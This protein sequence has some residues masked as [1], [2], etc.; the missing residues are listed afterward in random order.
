[1]GLLIACLSYGRLEAVRHKETVLAH[2]E[3]L[4][5][6]CKRASTLRRPLISNILGGWTKMYA[7]SYTGKT[8][9]AG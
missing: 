5:K 6:N 2:D 1:M 9:A 3:F 7:R 4:A 8:A